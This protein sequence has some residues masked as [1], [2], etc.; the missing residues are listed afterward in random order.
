VN[1]ATPK[2]AIL[3]AS[4]RLC[5]ASVWL[6]F[7]PLL[8]PCS[9]AIANTLSHKDAFTIAEVVEKFKAVGQEIQG[10]GGSIT[11]LND[12][13]ADVRAVATCLSFLQQQVIIASLKLNEAAILTA[14]SS[15]M[16][17]REDELLTIRAVSDNLSLI[18]KILP[19]I[20]QSVIGVSG[21]CFRYQI[22]TAEGQKILAAIEATYSKVGP[23]A[24]RLG[25]ARR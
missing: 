7:L 17:G 9:A 8:W 18:F 20:K 24:T 6:L 23:I 15:E 25:V 1:A 4:T 12:N 16:T 2:L 5:V 19:D 3:I 14:I 22:V 21:T 13:S 10:V 11:D